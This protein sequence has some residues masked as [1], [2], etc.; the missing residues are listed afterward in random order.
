MVA[1]NDSWGP[2]SIA[3]KLVALRKRPVNGSTAALKKNS[4]QENFVSFSSLENFSVI[5]FIP[6]SILIGFTCVKIISL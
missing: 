3:T 4:S 5:F 2:L 1:H 6:P